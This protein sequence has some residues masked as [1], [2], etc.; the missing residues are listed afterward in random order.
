MYII[1]TVLLTYPCHIQIQTS[2]IYLSD[3]HV[4]DIVSHFDV[5]YSDN[6]IITRNVL[7]LGT[8]YRWPCKKVL[9]LDGNK[10]GNV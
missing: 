4:V 8:F 2:T 5:T 6:N 1:N 3:K 9:K 10:E 7:N